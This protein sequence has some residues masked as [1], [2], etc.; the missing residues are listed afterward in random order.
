RGIPIPNATNDN[1][2]ISNVTSSSAGAYQV[3]VGNAAGTIMSDPAFL[4][5]K[6]LKEPQGPGVAGRLDP[7]F[8]PGSR[9]NGAAY[10]LLAREDGKTVVAGY[11]STVRGAS[12]NG[13]ALLNPDGSADLGF[14]P[15]VPSG[16]LSGQEGVALLDSQTN[17]LMA[18]AGQ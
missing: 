12:R 17:V 1:L 7:T 15:V 2:T 14:A 11:F 5:L 4:R 13:L 16:P 18:V 6:V 8:D 3:R 9:L 10:H